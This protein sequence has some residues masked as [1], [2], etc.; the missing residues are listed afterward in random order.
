MTG[1]SRQMIYAPEIN[2]DTFLFFFQKGDV[3]NSW[4]IRDYSVPNRPVGARYAHQFSLSLDDLWSKVVQ[5]F[6]A[7]THPT[8]DLGFWHRHTRDLNRTY[9]GKH[10]DA[11][12]PTTTSYISATTPVLQTAN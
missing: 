1:K 6:D 9:L 7:P 3:R 8:T 5:N 2:P 12:A 11:S 10:P 4:S